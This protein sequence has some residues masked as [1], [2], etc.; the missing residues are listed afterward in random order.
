MKIALLFQVP[1][2]WASWETLYKVAKDD[3]E[4][5]VKVFLVKPACEYQSSL[6]QMTDADRF[7]QRSNIIY[8]EYD[9]KSLI[10]FDPDYVIIQTPY[11]NGH[12][13]TN[14]WSIRF[15]LYG[16][17]VI[18]IPYGIEI[19]NTEESRYKHFNL[20]VVLNAYAIYTMSCEMKEEYKKHCVNADAAFGI[21]HPRFDLLKNEYEFGDNLKRKINGRKVIL[22]KVHFPKTFVENGI[23]VFATPDLSEYEKFISYIKRNE[24]LFFVFM[25][26]PKFA[27]N[28]LE[29]ELRNRAQTIVSKLENIPNVY[30]DRAEDYHTSLI[31]SDAIIVDRSAIMVEAGMLNK[32]VLYMYNKDYY[33]PMTRPIERLLRTY[34]QGTTYKEMAAFSERIKAGIDIKKEKR[35]NAANRIKSVSNNS[36]ASAILEDLKLHINDNYRISLPKLK[37]DRHK[38]YIWGTGEIGNLCLRHLN[39]N[40]Y[41][42]A[43][44]VDSNKNKKNQKI[45][46]HSIISPVDMDINS[47]DYIVIASDKY[48]TEIYRKVTE[49]M[50]IDVNKIMNY[51]EFIVRCDFDELDTWNSRRRR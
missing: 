14:A 3:A 28:T 23:R 31:C 46:N 8:E 25:P 37:M 35:D 42:I 30:I 36:I 5:Q 41:E 32:P 51:D 18:Y 15:K 33:E 26:H 39:P 11:D 27:D 9:F 4:C 49:N 29:E 16:I 17:K 43:S 21:G 19:S 34:E 38:V 7:L 44:F 1:S 13:D 47:V 6:I 12:R 40:K 24:A 22:W 20:S 50:R 10:S 2:F 48:Y 45:D